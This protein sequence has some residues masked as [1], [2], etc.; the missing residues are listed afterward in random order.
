M[1]TLALDC[2]TELIRPGHQAPG[3]A[4]VAIWAGDRAQSRLYGR[5]EWLGTFA[6]ILTMPHLQIVG[7]NIAFD[8]MVLGN[9]EPQLL[10]RIFQA[11]EQDRITCTEVRAKLLDIA[12]GQRKFHEDED[13]DTF[14]STYNLEDLSRRFLNR[15]LDKD[16]WR[17]RYGELK[18]IPVHQWPEGAR[19]Y[20]LEDTRA[21][22][23]LFQVQERNVGYLQDQYR[24]AR[25]SFWLRLMSAWGIH[26]DAQGVYE[27]AQR[28]QKDYDE[29]AAELRDIGPCPE[30]TR[31]RVGRRACKRCDGTGRLCLLRKDKT[32]R[33]RESGLVETV[34]G[35]RNTKEAARILIGAYAAQGKDYPKTDPSTKFPSGQAKLDEQ[36]CVD[37]G[38]LLLVQYAKATSLKTVLVK[39]IPALE[40]GIT[41]PIHSY[42]EVLLE[43]GR[44]SS[45]RPNIQNVRRLPGIREC[46]VPRPGYVFVSSDFG[47]LELCTLAQVLVT[48][49]KR[50]RLADAL[51]AG[52]DPHL[53]IAEKILG[54]DYATLKA[55]RKA[56]TQAD[57]ISGKTARKCACRYCQVDD[58]RQTGK[59]ANFGFP[60]GL[61]A[62]SLVAYALMCYGVRLTEKQAAELKRIWM[63]TWPEMRDYFAWINSQTSANFPMICQLFAGRFRG[64]PTYT[65]ACNSYFQGLG[66]DL[67][68]DAGWHIVK[69]CYVLYDSPLWGCRPVNFVHDEYILEA[70]EHRA[71]EAAQEMPRIMKARAKLWI[72][73]VKIECETVMMRRW[74]KKAKPLYDANGRMIAWAA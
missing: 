55:I 71:H 53:M 37:S 12:A 60:G 32:V 25:A 51:N 67:A 24:Q 3:L 63:A 26:A 54:W 58:A 70:P 69:A 43:T 65:A 48:K 34:P 45:S 28:T 14:K 44:T 52:W 61:G 33:R 31:G 38:N 15:R 66:A 18:D 5:T 30:C 36:A 72:P 42:F 9:E 41:T 35:S 8:M 17:L 16:T 57:C 59:V 22:L 2:E 39:D 7:H 68:K 56:G 74:S 40:G 46:F 1:F 23:D 4:C 73:D 13:G 19:T 27:L 64:N 29:I 50:S 21:T 49:F 47:G 62:E 20:P 11:Y 6:E 10:P